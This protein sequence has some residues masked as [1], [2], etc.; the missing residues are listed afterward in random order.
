MSWKTNFLKVIIWSLINIYVTTS[1]WNMN[2]ILA[3][4]TFLCPVLKMA[5]QWHG[6]YDRLLLDGSFCLSRSANL[7]SAPKRL[8][9]AYHGQEFLFCFV[10]LLV[11]FNRVVSRAQ[12]LSLCRKLPSLSFSAASCR[13]T[14]ASACA[15]AVA[16]QPC[17]FIAGSKQGRE[18]RVKNSSGVLSSAVMKAD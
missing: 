5:E 10:C 7:M 18:F 1:N 4:L 15:A 12:I 17:N 11:C 8:S 14:V 13:L 16:A 6:V 2:F 9:V 3:S